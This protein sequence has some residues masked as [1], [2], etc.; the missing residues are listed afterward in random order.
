MPATA[1]ARAMPPIPAHWVKNNILAAVISSAVSLC[2]HGMRLAT[3]AADA[4]AGL[5]AIV[6]LYA[7][8]II[9]WAFSGSA[10][11]LLTGAVL[12]RVVPSLPARIWI[13]LHALMAVVVGVGGE[14]AFMS[15]PGDS[16]GTDDVSMGEMMLVGFMLGAVIGAVVGGLQALVLRRAALG[17]EAWIGWS[18][19]AFAIAMAFVSGG[20]SLLGRGDGLAGELAN[21]ALV[22]LAAVII[23]VVMLPALER[24]RDRMLSRAGSYFS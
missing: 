8:A 22:F 23:S 16:K 11:G 10:D 13:G 7:I 5:G 14:L 1:D 4:D 20:A 9:L 24:L 21:Q 18:T 2:I 17:T 3:G 15:S 6:F 12:Q 19:A